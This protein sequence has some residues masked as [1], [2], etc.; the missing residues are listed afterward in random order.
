MRP[1]SVCRAEGE[2]FDDVLC[3]SRQP[4]NRPPRVDVARLE[5]E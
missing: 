4:P 2:P 1:T 3:E 5:L